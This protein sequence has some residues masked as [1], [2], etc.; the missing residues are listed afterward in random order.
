MNRSSFVRFKSLS[1]FAVLLLTGS[2][3]ACS[4]NLA[5]GGSCPML[6]PQESA[7]LKDTIV[8]AVVLDTSAAG[9][10]A[11]GFESN[12]V[13]A[14]RG[15]SLDSRVIS[16]YDSLP[17]TYNFAGVDSAIVRIDSAFISAPR[18]RA[19]SAVAFAADGRVEVYD[20]TDA[21]D[22]TAVA[23]LA[24]QFTAA[25][26]IGELAYTQGQSPDTLHILLD[27]ARVRD[28]LLNT[29][30]LRVGLRMV[31]AGSDQV[32]II[33]ANTSGG[34]TLTLVPNREESGERLKLIPGTYSPVEPTYLRSAYSDFTVSVVG[35]APDAN[36]LR[37]GGLPA[38][39]VLLRFNIPSYIVDSSV[40]VRASLLLTQRPSTSPDAGTSVSAQIVPIVASTLVTDLRTQ[41]EF[42]GSTVVFPVDSLTTVPK[43]S[44]VVSIEMV[45]LVRAWKGQDTV[46]TPRLAALY[47]S[48]E[49]TRFASFEFFSM[50]APAAVRPRLRITFVTRVNTGQP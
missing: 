43:D 31:S 42:A 28:R 1:I 48:S 46:K 44:G 38:H 40:V 23:S 36:V 9:F 19:D 4:E 10:P 33:S 24:A 37:V 49:A 16:R 41:L 22:D 8:D 32:N 35:A 6:C 45:R 39:R 15:D 18:P 29:R 34:I 14:H 50:E 21:V 30:S 13:L 12:L 2:L 17:Q 20:V 11:L 7:P 3:A 27:T 25:N 5:A 26:K 47:L